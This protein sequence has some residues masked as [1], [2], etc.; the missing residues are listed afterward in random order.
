VK[1]KVDISHKLAFSV[2]KES[3]L[4]SVL[5]VLYIPFLNGPGKRFVAREITLQNI[6]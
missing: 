3:V 1:C 2:R 4:K 6:K 5:M